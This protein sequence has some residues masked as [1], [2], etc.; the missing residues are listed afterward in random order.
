M[1]ASRPCILQLIPRLDTGGAEQATIDITGALVKAG[2]RALVAT[3]GGRMACSVIELGGE[4]VELP[5][6]TKNP[7]AIW[8]NARRLA[9]LCVAQGVALIHARSRAPAFSGLMAARR[10]GIPFV[11]TYHGAYGG[12]SAVKTWYNGV[13]ARGDA[14]IANSRY[15]ARLIAERHNSPAER[16]HV[17]PR[18][19]DLV[20]F[21]PAAV[22]PARIAALRAQWGVRT[23][24]P[25]IVSAARLTDW[26]GQRV[27]VDAA[28]LLARDGRLG[29]A[30][31]VLAGDAQ[32]RDGY[33]EELRVAISKAG[34][35]AQVILGGHC[36]DIPAA[37]LTA[38]L[39][40]IASTKPEAFGRVSAE[41]LAMGTPVVSTNIGAPPET[42]AHPGGEQLG[43]LVL[44]GDAAALA[45]A[46]AAALNL[47][48]AERARL[49]LLARE[50]VAAHFSLAQMQL[51]TL[52]LY[53]RLLGTDMAVAF[54]RNQPLITQFYAE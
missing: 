30:A 42:L 35:G 27:I 51:G 17:I 43:W 31:V 24:Q 20:R 50:H 18:G 16:I 11:A 40:V 49:G 53:D 6:A 9:R 3:E 22:T 41:S 37:F 7:A 8:W 36:E 26:K 44:P 25:V 32:G 4:I 45:G 2:A 28:A 15:T 12:T 39:S 29:D 23:D 33:V 46:M 54:S 10:L 47:P 38:T 13:M 34:L 52:V 19:I 1:P 48:A 14:V 5:L 21:D